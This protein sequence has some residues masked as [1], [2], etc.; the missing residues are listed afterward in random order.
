[1]SQ[2]LDPKKWK[3]AE[4]YMEGLIAQ[5]RLTLVFQGGRAYW[6]TNGG[7]EVDDIRVS[8]DGVVTVVDTEGN[9]VTDFPTW[10]DLQATPLGAT[11]V[12]FRGE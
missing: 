6:S 12:Q 10:A 9:P 1:M 4:T 5:D 8:E 3:Q 2:W 11:S 7:V